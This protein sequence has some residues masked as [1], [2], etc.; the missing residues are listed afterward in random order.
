MCI[1]LDGLRAHPDYRVFY[2][3]LGHAQSSVASTTITIFFVC[4]RGEI[5]AELEKYPK[6]C[7]LIG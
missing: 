1:W 2:A 5:A 4:E 6:P 3:L 7:I